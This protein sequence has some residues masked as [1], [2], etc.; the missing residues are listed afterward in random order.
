[1]STSTLSGDQTSGLPARFH[2]LTDPPAERWQAWW[3][4]ASERIN[5]IVV[6]EVRQA[7][8]SKQFSISF[9]LTLLAALVWTV[10]YVVFSVPRLYYIP[11][12]SALLSGYLLIL[13]IPLMIIIPFG[14]F[15]SMSA[16][17]DDSTFELLSIS[18][19]SAVQ[20]IGGK[21]ASSCL[22]IVLYLSALAPCIVLTYVLRR[23]DLFTIGFLLLTSLYFSVVETAV[24]LALAAVTRVRMLQIVTSVGVLAG[25]FG[26]FFTWMSIMFSTIATARDSSGEG[27]VTLFAVG[28][29]LASLIAVILRAGAAAIDFPA[30][31][32]STPIRVR[33]LVFQ[34]L[35]TFWALL[36]YAAYPFEP[37]LVLVLM[38][39]A[40]VLGVAG[41]LMAGERGILSPRAQ[42]GLPKTFAGRLFKTWFYPG[43]GLGYVFLV[44]LFAAQAIT[45]SVAEMYH[46]AA[47]SNVFGRESVTMVSCLLVCYLVFYVGLT[48]LTMWLVP[49][50]VPFR[51]LISVVAAFFLLTLFHLVPLAAEYYWN[52][53]QSFDYGAIQAFNIFWTLA[54]AIDG[55]NA[56][57]ALGLGVMSVG[58]VCVFFINLALSTRDV[59]LVRIAAPPRIQ[60]EEQ[61]VQAQVVDPFAD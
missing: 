6:K 5:P 47:T 39:D 10:L 55:N 30:E 34:S 22:Q 41:T 26:L 9:G 48:R 58:A 45:F 24:A 52:N 32:H 21:M 53:F 13:A 44:C 51:Q 61:P 3:A 14:A 57:A 15:R 54:E 56:E 7:L 12:G 46:K 23:V 18:G 4:W 17:T 11:S 59:M 43:A 25:L 8:K 16:E 42:R 27:G 1:M 19:L 31:N 60:Q 50:T 20:I 29:I 49:R 40:A 33:L 38:L 2:Y 35:L 36:A 37:T 28:T